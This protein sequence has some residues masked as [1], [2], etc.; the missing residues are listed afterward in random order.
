MNYG[1]PDSELLAIVTAFKVWR[2]YLEG[3]KHQTTVFSD[4]SNLQRFNT[5]KELTRR[6]AQWAEYLATFDFIIQF[7]PGTSNP[8]DGLSRRADYMDK[9]K[10][11]GGSFLKFAATD[12]ISMELITTGKAMLMEARSLTIVN[13]N[14]DWLG[15]IDIIRKELQTD[16]FTTDKK[17]NTP[18]DNPDFT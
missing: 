18:N 10:A 16:E 7:R 2:H 4:H 3:A 9:S 17:T 15:L 11:E 6:T 13:T 12:E 14:E 1:I 5:T 8:A